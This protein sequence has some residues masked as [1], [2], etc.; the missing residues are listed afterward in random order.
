MT[1]PRH[2]Y[3]RVFTTGFEA[4]EFWTSSPS[5]GNMAIVTDRVRTGTYAMRYTAVSGT[6]S[7]I[8]LPGPSGS[9]YSSS[10]DLFFRGYLYIESLPSTAR[11]IL[12]TSTTTTSAGHAYVK[13]NSDGTMSLTV[14]S[15][16]YGTTASG[17]SVNTWYRIEW[18]LGGSTGKQSLRIDGADVVTG[19]TGRT[20]TN[21]ASPIIGGI[22]T[23]SS[24][25]TMVWDDLAVDYND[26]PGEGNV[27]LFKPTGYGTDVQS[28]WGVTG[29]ATRWEAIDELPADDATSYLTTASQARETYTYGSLPGDATE[30]NGVQTLAKVQRSGGSN[31]IIDFGLMIGTGGQ[32]TGKGTTASTSSWTKLE[33]PILPISTTTIG[34]GVWTR[35]RFDDASE[36][37][38][39][40]SSANNT[41]VTALAIEVDYTT[42]VSETQAVH[43]ILMETFDNGLVDHTVTGTAAIST[44]ESFSGNSSLRVNPTGNTT[45]YANINLPN[46]LYFQTIAFR[47]YVGAYPVSQCRLVEMNGSTTAAHVL[48]SS[49]G[50]LRVV[51]TDGTA[52]GSFSTETIPLNTWTLVEVQCQFAGSSDTS[53]IVRV[54]IDGVLV[55]DHTGVKNSFSHNGSTIR[56]GS[57]VSTGMANIDFFYDNVVVDAGA[58]VGDTLIHELYPIGTGTRTGTGWSVTG[59]STDWEA[60]DEN[61]TDDA[62]SYV[63]TGTTA[64]QTSSYIK[65]DLPDEAGYIFGV[66]MLNRQVR[67]GGSTGAVFGG[68]LFP[69]VATFPDPSSIFGTANASYAW[70]R[71]PIRSALGAVGMFTPF[72]INT[73]ELALKSTSAN[74]SN[75]S[76]LRAYV[77]YEYLDPIYEESLDRVVDG[78]VVSYATDDVVADGVILATDTKG[79]YVTGVV[80]E[81]DKTISRV[82]DGIIQQGKNSDVVADGVVLA[83]QHTSVISSGLLFEAD[84][85]INEVTSGLV[86]QQGLTGD[87]VIDG[88]V[89]DAFDTHTFDRSAD[90][91]VK[92]VYTA[93]EVA[94]G[95]VQ[96]TFTEDL[97]AGGNVQQNDQTVSRAADAHLVRPDIVDLTADANVFG[98]YTTERVADGTIG[99]YITNLTRERIVD[100]Y[101]TGAGLG[102]EQKIADAIVKASDSRKEVTANGVVSEQPLGGRLVYGGAGSGWGDPNTWLLADAEEMTGSRIVKP[103]YSSPFMWTPS[104]NYA[105]GGVIIP[106]PGSATYDIDGTLTLEIGSYSGGVYA[107]MTT[108]TLPKSARQTSPGVELYH[109]RWATAQN[110]TAGTTYY[111]TVVPTTQSQPSVITTAKTVDGLASYVLNA[112]I[113]STTVTTEIEARSVVVAPYV[114]GGVRDEI[115]LVHDYEDGMAYRHIT[116][117]PGATLF[118]PPNI[119]A[120]LKFGMSFQVGAGASLLMEAFDGFTHTL[121]A[122][123]A[124]A[125]YI[126]NGFVSCAG[127]AKTR[128]AKIPGTTSA[129][130]TSI[131][132]AE[133]PAGWVAGDQIVIGSTDE[134]AS[135]TYTISSVDDAIV[136]LTS[137]ITTALKTNAVVMNL[138]RNVRI[139]GKSVNALTTMRMNAGSTVVMTSVETR[140]LG[141]TAGIAPD[142]ACDATFDDLLILHGSAI[143]NAAGPTGFIPGAM[144]NV[145]DLLIW[146]YRRGIVLS[147]NFDLAGN[148]LLCD[149]NVAHSGLSVSGKTN[150]YVIG[151]GLNGAAV[152]VGANAQFIG[153]IE[154]HYA[155]G[156]TA[157]LVVCGSGTAGL[158]KLG[159]G[160]LSV[161]ETGYGA[162]I[163]IG[164]S[165]SLAMGDIYGVDCSTWPVM[166]SAGNNFVGNCVFRGCNFHMDLGIVKID[167]EAF[168]NIVEED[169]VRNLGVMLATGTLL[170]GS[171]VSNQIRTETAYGRHE[172]S[173]L[174]SYSGTTSMLVVANDDAVYETEITRIAVDTDEN[175]RL[176]FWVKGSGLMALRGRV[177]EQETVTFNATDWTQMEL[178]VVPASPGVVVLAVQK[179]TPD[180]LFID[181]I[182]RY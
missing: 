151:A 71:R 110:L 175:V 93:D 117:C 180:P 156:P 133:G 27:V 92:A 16:T 19:V 1:G 62:S 167:G 136:H 44:S 137:A 105:C 97:I 118:F 57:S 28:G 182:E 147:G 150:A 60:L 177:V 24:T 21:M 153:A 123:E 30:V 63:G 32:V 122:T 43:R 155:F 87:V 17:L 130:A 34:A 39:V 134:T 84:R 66:N 22:D 41:N 79:M 129:G 75:V 5:N 139:L 116:I 128:Y 135:K 9:G 159:Y 99:G 164:P 94:S 18:A 61:P 55:Q 113:V 107:P 51:D 53:G 132:C 126:F 100:A 170:P 65:G 96:D 68:M 54:K 160:Y 168:V 163:Y 74:P 4:G 166:V 37:F 6:K 64:D 59:A 157:S 11:A 13:L 145:T 169:N 67:A 138:S 112:I 42:V 29:A 50:Q 174:D 172:R 47:L 45:S 2:P 88:I 111:V 127:T 76:T 152:S 14:G 31:G 101:V 10:P 89:D 102:F 48:I 171:R 33:A 181:L 125:S 73:S 158:V 38:I 179:A 176:R 72:E 119:N 141:P 83:T 70:R 91:V 3:A 77:E 80:L 85:T 106:L 20:T 95:I 109:V 115:F 46:Q 161:L 56:L 7:T 162:A 144:T 36:L 143:S 23:V 69:G 154:N 86:Q 165:G 82:A 108:A 49:T 178:E 26:W 40:N 120:G 15:T 12:G 104:V 103:K 114:S 25:M 35:E 81:H 8:Q 121:E 90:G 142:N 173:D 148:T 140:Y 124:D 98:T 52:L 78:L 149:F 146:R 58:W 131:V